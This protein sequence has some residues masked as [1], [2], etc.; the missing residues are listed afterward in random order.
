MSQ[1]DFD[2]ANASGATVRA[3]INAHLDAMATLSSGAT[4]PATTF[5]NQWWVD[6]STGL[7]KMRNTANTAFLTVGTLNL[8]NL[9]LQTVGT[10]P[11]SYLAGLTLSNNS[12]DAT[13]DID[14][15]IGTA[16]NADDDGNLKL[17]AVTGKQIDVTWAAGGTPGA[18]TGGMSSSLTVTN[19]T[20]YH[21]HLI[22]VSG[23]VEVGFDTSV[24]AANLITDHSATEFRRIGSVRRGTATNLGF[25]QVGDQFLWDD[26]PLDVNTA[27]QSTSSIS[28]T[29][30]TPLGVKTEAVVNVGYRDTLA[31]ARLYLRSL[32]VN[33]EAPSLTVAPLGASTIIGVSTGTLFGPARYMTNT[34]SQIGARASVALDE[35]TIATL[36]W[37]DLR[38]KD[39]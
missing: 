27:A 36:G 3:D 24:V 26:P 8:P 17:A 13:N 16:R 33:D 38:G 39:D 11:R 6:T 31:S 32:D 28:Y 35:F 30:T 23:V 12:G 20:W 9:D 37:I 34:S 4:A 21:V 10:V 18:P 1:T 25:S 14:I 15:A 19:D 2:V 29:L 22:L 5:P 7:L